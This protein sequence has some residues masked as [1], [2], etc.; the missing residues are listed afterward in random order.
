ML[1]GDT[2]P[3]CRPRHAPPILQ[4]TVGFSGVSPEASLFPSSSS[5]PASSLL[6]PPSAEASL[7]PSSSSSP[8]SLP[9]SYSEVSELSVGWGRQRSQADVQYGLHD[10]VVERREAAVDVD[11]ARE[12]PVRTRQLV[13]N[14]ARREVVLSDFA[15]PNS[16]IRST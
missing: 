4:A 13:E 5:S 3:W 2:S 16:P 11:G 8:H 15:L 12:E 9:S 14:M 6:P 1:G 10:G 7:L